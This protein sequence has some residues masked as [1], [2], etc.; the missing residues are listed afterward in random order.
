M[1]DQIETVLEETIL[2]DVIIYEGETYGVV[3]TCDE[4]VNVVHETTG[5]WKTLPRA[6]QVFKQ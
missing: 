6:T 3:G 1:T 2:G 5:E 4:G